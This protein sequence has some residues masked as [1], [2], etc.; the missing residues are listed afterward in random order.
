MFHFP[1]STLYVQMV[2]TQLTQV[3]FP[4]SGPVCIIPAYYTSSGIITLARQLPGAYRRP[5][6]R[7]QTL[8]A[9]ASTDANKLNKT[10][11]TVQNKCARSHYTNLA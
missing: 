8:D 9:K 11:K 6:R 1:R 3:R 4:I 7:N 10:Q 5:Q 2:V